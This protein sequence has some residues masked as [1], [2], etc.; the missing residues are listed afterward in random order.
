MDEVFGKGRVAHRVRGPHRLAKTYLHA[1]AG[2]I[3]LDVQ[4][5]SRAGL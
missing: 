2:S 5:F 4:Q 3:T 1:V